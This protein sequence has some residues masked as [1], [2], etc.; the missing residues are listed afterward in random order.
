MRSRRISAVLMAALAV[1]FVGLGAAPAFGASGPQTP[2]PAPVTNYAAYPL[3]L[4]LIPSGCTTQGEAMLTGEQYSMNGGAPVGSL[5]ALGFVPNNA[6]IT[7]TW[8]GYAP[9]CEG[10]GVSLSRKVALSTTFD[11]SVNQYLN[12]WSYCGPGGTACN[13]TLT[14]DLSQSDGVACYQL[15]A[16]AGPP[17]DVV[18]PDGAFYSL[19]GKFNMLISANNGG[20]GNCAPAPCPNAGVPAD[21]P[22]TASSCVPTTTTTAPP[23]TT[24]TTAPPA[25][26]STQA[27]AVTTT[28]TAPCVAGQVRDAVTGSCVAQ[29]SAGALPFTGSPTGDL[30]RFGLAMAAAGLLIAAAAHR[31][32]T[33]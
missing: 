4:G 30:A 28:T 25:P 21:M 14:L 17:L 11:Q 7:M 22:S 5:G 20:A 23:T 9:G 8:T 18:G 32:R 1:V 33:A 31:W 13:G 15:D 27:P 19:N 6:T 24:T 2:S 10:I 26:S 3:G 12:V 29:V 16:N